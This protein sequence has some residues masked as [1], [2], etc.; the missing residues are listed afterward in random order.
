M[1]LISDGVCED[2]SRH[3]LC[4]ESVATSKV[5]LAHPSSSKMSAESGPAAAGELTHWPNCF[6]SSFV[7]IT[8]RHS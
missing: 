5:D 7:Q 4:P 3:D 1:R 6:P 2:D 8:M